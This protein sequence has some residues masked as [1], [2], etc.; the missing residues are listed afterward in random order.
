MKYFSTNNKA[1]RVSFREATLK[2]L[3]EDGGLFMPV[4]IHSLLSDFWKN[5]SS[6]SFKEISFESA[7]LFIEEEIP[8]NNLEKIIDTTINFPA[9]LVELNANKFVLELF[10]GP[11]LAFKDFGARFMAQTMAYFNKD[12]QKELTILVATSGDTGSAVAYGFHNV[13]G[14]KVILLYPSDKV[15]QIQEKQLTTIGGNITAL[16]ILGNFDDCQTL[17]KQAFTNPELNKKL[18]LTSANSI[19]IARLIPQSFYYLNAFALLKEKDKPLYIAVPSGNFGNLTAGLFAFKLGLPVEKFIAALNVNK[20]FLDYLKSGK[21]APRPSVK[22]LSNAMDVGNPSNF[23]RIIDLFNNDH[24]RI[25][26]LIYSASFT[27]LQTEEAVKSFY[28]KYEYI[29]DPHGAV[30]QLAMDEFLLTQNHNDF[31]AIVLETA[32]PAKFLD[33]IDENLSQMIDMPERLKKCL[34]KKKHSIKLS[35]D[36]ADLKDFLL[37]I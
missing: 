27:D 12:E 34:K 13:E 21:F 5:I 1:I 11:T 9:P 20:V 14:I 30:G 10:H 36:F 24:K 7:K 6:K 16:E 15:S 22:T 18:R 25:S 19:N 31:N 8:E 3:A 33:S 26:N 32:H 35:S 29:F 28:N 2:G 4:E 23:N 17:V 37:S